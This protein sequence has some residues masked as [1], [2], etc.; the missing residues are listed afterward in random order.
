M[1]PLSPERPKRGSASQLGY[2]ALYDG[3]MN[4]R[5]SPRFGRPS[6]SA[7]YRLL[8][9][10]GLIGRK[11][12]GL[13]QLTARTTDCFRLP[14]SHAFD[15][16]VGNNGGGNTVLLTFSL[17]NESRPRVYRSTQTMTRMECCRKCRQGRPCHTGLVPYCL[18]WS[19][20][21]PASVVVVVAVAELE[22]MGISVGGRYRVRPAR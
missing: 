19:C 14:A 6:R 13:M 17:T 9:G 8:D 3:F 16:A 11:A 1:K 7:P 20:F 12:Q 15:Y 21:L 22:E 5:Q 2:R 18:S 4:S 10:S